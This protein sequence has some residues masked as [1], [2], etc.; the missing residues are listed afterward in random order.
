MLVF[1]VWFCNG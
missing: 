1:V